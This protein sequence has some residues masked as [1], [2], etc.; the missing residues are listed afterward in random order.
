MGLPTHCLPFPTTFSRHS[1]LFRKQ[2]EN[3]QFSSGH[4]EGSFVNFNGNVAAIKS[5]NVSP[6]VQTSAQNL[7]KIREKEFSENLVFVKLFH[8]DV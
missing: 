7:E 8:V 1:F 3:P 2:I 5:Q 6:K 4:L